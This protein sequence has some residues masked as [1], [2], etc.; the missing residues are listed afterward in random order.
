MEQKKVI[1]KL[2][3]DETSFLGV[4]PDCSASL[5]R[6]DGVTD[7]KDGPYAAPYGRLK[8]VTAGRQ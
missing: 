8:R 5:Q 1:S 6:V 7:N 3:V 2:K 4:G